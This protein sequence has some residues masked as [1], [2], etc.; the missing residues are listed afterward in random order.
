MPLKSFSKSEI[1]GEYLRKGFPQRGLIDISVS[2]YS[3]GSRPCGICRS[4]LRKY[5]AVTL[6]HVYW[7]FD[8]PSDKVMDDFLRESITKNRKFE[9]NDIKKCIELRKL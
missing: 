7:N 5:V 1:V 3:G 4:C 9:I 8:H 6:N 2:C